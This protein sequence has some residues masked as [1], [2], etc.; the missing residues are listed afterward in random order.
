MQYAPYFCATSSYPS[1]FSMVRSDTTL[2]GCHDFDFY[3]AAPED[4]VRFYEYLFGL[5]NTP[6]SA[7]PIM[8][9]FEPDFLNANHQCVPRFIQEV[10]AADA[11]F[12]AQ[13][14]VALARG[15]PIQWCFCTPL[16]LMWTLTAPAVTN[17]RVSYDYAYGGS[18]DIGRSSL[19]VWAMGSA[20]SKVSG[21]PPRRGG[22]GGGAAGW[23]T[24]VAP[25]TP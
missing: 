13:A 6:G 23:S 5:Y 15:I 7:S 2:P 1:N 25:S 18:W 20:P 17:F 19:L 22:G 4:A 14:S 9:M 11:F 3:D 21:L 12:G 8:T 10:G 24:Q 16:L